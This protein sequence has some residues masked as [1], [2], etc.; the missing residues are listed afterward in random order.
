[1]GWRYYLQRQIFM[2]TGVFGCSVVTGVVGF[3]EMRLVVAARNRVRVRQLR[4]RPRALAIHVGG[5]RVLCAISR[6]TRQ[7]SK[8]TRRVRGLR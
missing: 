4:W 3:A 6:P 5:G 7:R 2:E 1:M 8:G